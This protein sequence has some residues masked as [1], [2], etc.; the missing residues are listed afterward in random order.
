[1]LR[2][3]KYL[4]W[5]VHFRS[6]LGIIQLSCGLTCFGH[7]SFNSFPPVLV[8]LTCGNWLWDCV[9]VGLG[10]FSWFWGTCSGLGLLRG[11]RGNRDGECSRKT[12]ARGCLSATA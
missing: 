2:S 9:I 10:V 8:G 6:T 7:L 3:S 12:S 5:D 11:G 1:M 4:C